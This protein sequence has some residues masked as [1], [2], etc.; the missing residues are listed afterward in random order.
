MW[1]VMF[2]I[3]GLSVVFIIMLLFVWFVA[4]IVSSMQAA[5]GLAEQAHAQARWAEEQRR[6]NS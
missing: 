6:R 3:I 2:F 5:R 1:E 4:I